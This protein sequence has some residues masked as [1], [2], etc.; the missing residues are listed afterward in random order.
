MEGEKNTA[1]VTGGAGFIGSHLTER[2]LRQGYIVR[3][4]GRSGVRST[5]NLAHLTGHPNLKIIQRNLLRLTPEDAVFKGVDVIFHLAAFTDH[6]A[7]QSTPELFIDTNT[8]ML[9]RVLAAARIHGCKIIYTSSAAVYGEAAWPTREDHPPQPLNAYGLSKWIGEL[10]LDHWHVI[11]AIPY[12]TFR[13][14]NGYGPRNSTAGVFGI[15]LKKTLEGK[16]LT[17]TGDGNAQ[18]DFVYIDD[19]VAA[20]VRGAESDADGAAYNVG[21]GILRPVLDMATL[22]G[23]KLEY[24]PPRAEEP[25]V[26]CADIS[27]IKKELGW[28]PHVTL[29]EGVRKT[30]DYY[31]HKR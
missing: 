2:L 23:G 4:I 26:Y 13:I 21:T 27:K 1:L 6:V 3:V 30:L 31:Q 28:T 14:F 15:F 29:E 20:L 25:P 22:L 9:T 10:L 5:R 24:I 17:I 7:S 11:Y 12:L 8:Q 18:R 19:I 16:S